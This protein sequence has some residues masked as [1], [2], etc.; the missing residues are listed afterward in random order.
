M[1]PHYNWFE[2]DR[3]IRRALMEDM[4]NG[5]I[6]T[7]CVITG[8]LSARALLTAKAQGVVA[9][10]E[11]AAR[12]FSTLDEGVKIRF[13]VND[14][15]AVNPGTDLMEVVGHGG[16]M[17]S[18]ERTAL[19]LLQRMSGIATAVRRFV[20]ALSGFPVRVTDT[21]KTAPGLRSLDKAAVLIGGGRNHRFSLSDG[22]MLKDNHIALA[23]GIEN[24][25][26]MA[27]ERIPH[28]MTIEVEV[29]TLSQ[30]E[31]AL[32][33][34][35]D[36]IMLDNMTP[37]DMAEAVKLAKGRA[38]IEASGNMTA[39]RALKAAMAGVDVISVGSLTHSVAAMDISMNI[40]GIIQ[41]NP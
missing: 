24:A 41:G 35:A 22:V 16:A 7:A 14:G 19:N 3:I 39:E 26:R 37:E 40:T 27:R 1:K 31:E 13:L 32:R 6:S 17:L 38:V 10:L 11:V 29:K 15:D 25:V 12:V 23:G 8:P 4:P 28:T 34:K 33:A 9:G 21:R 18:A 5:D 20:E 2:V 30:V 36:I